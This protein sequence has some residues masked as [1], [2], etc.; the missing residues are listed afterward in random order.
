MWSNEGEVVSSDMEAPPSAG[1]PGAAAV[2]RP[3]AMPANRASAARL[4]A[5]CRYRCPGQRSNPRERRGHAPWREGREPSR[6]GASRLM[7][8]APTLLRKRLRLREVRG[9]AR[10][11]LP[12]LEAARDAAAQGGAAVA[13]RVEVGARDDRRVGGDIDGPARAREGLLVGVAVHED[14]AEEE[15]PVLADHLPPVGVG[16]AA[17][18]GAL[19]RDGE[20]VG[21]RLPARH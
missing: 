13:G 3:P 19:H 14:A 21:A 16:V 6:A 10:W 8:S 9:E 7:P 20:L 2:A 18:V 12:R 4:T 5:T 1:S 11:R 15:L 17:A